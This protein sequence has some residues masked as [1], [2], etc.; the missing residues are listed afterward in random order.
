MKAVWCC[1]TFI[2]V[3]SVVLMIVGNVVLT[4]ARSTNQ[5]NT[6]DSSSGEKPEHISSARIIQH[7]TYRVVKTYPHDPTAFTQGLLYDGGILYESTGL[8]GR[9][10]LRAVELTTGSI[11][12][13]HA[14]PDQFFGEGLTAFE[15]KLIQLTWRSQVGFV[16][17]RESFSLR[18]QFIYPTEGWGLTSDGTRLIM[19]D[20]SAT[21]YF[22]DPHS[23]TENGRIEVRDHAGPISGLNELE[24]VR[25]QI[26]AN[27]YPTDAIV[28]IDPRT[29][30]VTGQIDL[31]GLLLLERRDPTV[32]ILNGIAYDTCT[33]RL[34]VTGKLWPKL[35]EIEL[36]PAQ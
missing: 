6:G 32:Q 25:G 11:L 36:M 23:F 27:V 29:G 18:A 13:Q 30:A 8:H 15:D 7:Y 5:V 4:Y 2:V 26:L 3:L 33:N 21:L 28:R 22:L 9:S 24:Y 14:L 34:W 19:S 10:S 17:D 31:Q 1:G 20:G 12:K 16:Y 35:F